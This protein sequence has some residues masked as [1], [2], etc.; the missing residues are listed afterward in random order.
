MNLIEAIKSGRPY[1]RKR[2]EAY[3]K[4]N[5]EG[6]MYY[7][8]DVLADDW[9]IEEAELK[10]KIGNTVFLKGEILSI[11]KSQSNK[12][13]YLVKLSCGSLC[14]FGED[15]LLKKENLEI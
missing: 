3:I 10:F 12:P 13:I 7:E 5:M 11:S 1:K 8:P 6:R 15:L 9:E 4:S 14:W 2:H